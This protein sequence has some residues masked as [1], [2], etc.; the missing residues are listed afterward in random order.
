MHQ[1]RV[2][3]G[4]AALL[5]AGGILH[6]QTFDVDPGWQLLGATEELNATAF[7]QS[8]C[9]NFLWKYDP[10]ADNGP[11]LI[12]V[13]NG[14][15][16][17]IDDV[18]TFT[19]IHKNE[20]FWLN[21]K[22]TCQIDVNTTQAAFNAATYLQSIAGKTVYL[23]GE[24]VNNQYKTLGK[25][26]F[27][28]GDDT[29]TWKLEYNIIETNDWEEKDE[30][31]TF[32]VTNNTIRFT[33]NDDG[34]YTVVTQKGGQTVFADYDANGQLESYHYIFTDKAAAQAEYDKLHKTTT[35]GLAGRTLY[36]V[37]Y[38]DYGYN[39]LGVRWNMASV[40]F[41]AD[42]AYWQEYETHDK[43]ATPMPYTLKDG[44]LTLNSDTYRIYH[45]ND[46]M[47]LCQSENGCDEKSAIFV[48]D[49]E[50]DA[51]RFR[52]EKRGYQTDFNLTQA[53]LTG[54]T[55]YV[56]SAKTLEHLTMQFGE[57]NV[58]VLNATDPK[59]QNG[60]YTLRGNTIDFGDAQIHFV[61][62]TDDFYEGYFNRPASDI[63]Q[64]EDKTGEWDADTVKSFDNN[65]TKLKDYFLQNGLWQTTITADGKINK[66]GDAPY[67]GYWFIEDNTFYFAYPDP[68]DGGHLGIKAYR[69]QNDHIY[70]QTD[71]KIDEIVRFYFDKDKRDQ[72]LNSILVGSA[73]E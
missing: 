70:F 12:H 51:L 46:K 13:A 1:K 69:V 49:D 40:K 29:K 68:D 3:K 33:Q 60:S 15:S 58:S 24:G 66:Y 19:T 35:P 22:E 9:V 53:D 7:D 63:S 72:W 45:D 34:S 41:E 10:K 28:Q 47:V 4:M 64:W 14:K 30:N 26:V 57:N 27:T 11:W 37:Q 17:Q 52:D 55:F 56:G 48:F 36:F 23:I 54:K 39:D 25:A 31:L 16:Y 6:A 20:G 43:R 50:T 61:A 38:D 42:A 5:V 65:A 67:D 21:A 18:G 71:A 44:N 32:T 73:E 8:G 2:Q 62:K 59:D